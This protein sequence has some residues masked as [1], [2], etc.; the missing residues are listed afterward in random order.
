ME[1]D[2]L[3]EALSY[4]EGLGITLTVIGEVFSSIAPPLT[5][6]LL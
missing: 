3:R 1:I 5:E 2:E 4:D 6:P